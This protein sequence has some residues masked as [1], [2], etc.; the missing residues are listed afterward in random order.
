[1]T[2]RLVPNQ[3]LQAAPE[4]EAHILVSDGSQNYQHVPVSTITDPITQ[5]VDN[6]RTTT[7]QAVDAVRTTTAQAVDNVRTTTA[8][9][10]AAVSATAQQAIEAVNAAQQAIADVKATAEKAV[11]DVLYSDHQLSK[12][13]IEGN[14]CTF[15]LVPRVPLTLP[16]EVTLADA[17][18]Q[19]G[20]VVSYTVKGVG[21]PAENNVYGAYD[22]TVT[23]FSEELNVDGILGILTTWKLVAPVQTVK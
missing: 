3:Q 10:V 5:A 16:V 19:T 9:A 20:I 8:Q 2:K 6:V 4:K 22:V 14:S 21:D 7:A 23:D 17:N 13:E 1:M 12:S 15:R 11:M 18:G